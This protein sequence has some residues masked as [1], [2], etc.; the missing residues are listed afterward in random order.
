[1]WNSKHIEGESRENLD[2]CVLYEVL[3]CLISFYFVSK[4]IIQS[5]KT[6]LQGELLYSCWYVRQRNNM[7]QLWRDVQS[8]HT[9]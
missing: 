4:V 6:W 9:E 2:P 3:N 5:D 1:M 8:L 7:E